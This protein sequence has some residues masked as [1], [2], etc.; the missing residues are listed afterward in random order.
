MLLYILPISIWGGVP[1]SLDSCIQLAQTNNKQI[2]QA[3]INIHKAQQ[4]KQQAFTKYFP[5]VSA[6]AIS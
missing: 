3:N 5:Q 1:L 6:S 4:V 2:I